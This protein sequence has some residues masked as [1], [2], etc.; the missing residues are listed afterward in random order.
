MSVAVDNTFFNSTNIL[1]DFLD[2]INLSDGELIIP[3]YGYDVNKEIP[4]NT[5]IQDTEKNIDVCFSSP[6]KKQRPYRTPKIPSWAHKI[7][8]R[9]LSRMPIQNSY[10]K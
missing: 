2:L 5:I 8:D 4:I 1:D 3:D 9:I 10:G 7:L 6:I